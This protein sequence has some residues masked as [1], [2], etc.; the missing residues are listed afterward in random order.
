M[1]DLPPG[2]FA[3]Y[4]GRYADLVTDAAIPLLARHGHGGVTLKSLADAM[5]MTAPGVRRWFGSIDGTW[6]A[7][8]R[9][10]GQ[11]WSGWLG[12][13]LERAPD[14]FASGADT[15]DLVL[16]QTPEELA[17]ARAWSSMLDRALLDERLAAV[18]AFWEHHE[19]GAMALLLSRHRGELS[20]SP[21]L[22]A[23]VALARGLRHAMIAGDE[24][25]ALDEA[26]T[27]LRRGLACL[28]PPVSTRE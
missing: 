25:L 1:T 16:P 18:M 4:S 6:S 14:R 26:R 8:A 15:T 7:I 9:T 11:R 19:E 3:P 2:L 22:T 10:F 13:V 21:E 28:L 12:R 27:A 24:P 17:A 5:G 23:C 20:D